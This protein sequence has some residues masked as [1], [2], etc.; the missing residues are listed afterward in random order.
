MEHMV[1]SFAYTSQFPHV[2]IVLKTKSPNKKRVL[3]CELLHLTGTMIKA[4]ICPLH[5]MNLPG[6]EKPIEALEEK[7]YQGN[8]LVWGVCHTGTLINVRSCP[9][10]KSHHS[11]G[12]SQWHGMN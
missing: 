1:A 11:C 9:D 4:R 7:R 2:H 6:Q 5:P 3:L 8:T 12:P 10:C